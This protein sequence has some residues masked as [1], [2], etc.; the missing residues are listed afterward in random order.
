M[1]GLK[2]LEEIV[3]RLKALADPE[4]IELKARKFN[5]SAEGSLGIYQKDLK[6]LSNEIVKDNQLAV[7]LFD[8]GIYEA[9]LICSRIF[10][11]KD[12]TTDLM[13]KWVITFENWEIVDSFCMALF[14]H[15]S[16]AYPKAMEWSLREREFEKRSG[17][18]IM[19][20]YCMAN[21]QAE[22]EEY[23]D[24]LERIETESCDDRIYVKKA[25]NWALRNIG[26]RNPDLKKSAISSSRKI[27][28]KE[29]K[30][31]QWIANDALKEF[32]KEG[33][34]SSDYPRHLYRKK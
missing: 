34:R 16:L 21:K 26:K 27:L 7:D 23:L 13:E 33:L 32:E 12:L 5:I 18:A 31:A 8:T 28:Q 24:F 4:K 25:A 9:R 10:N 19:A 22:N 17:F 1:R 11:P 15:S 14:A 2:S 3:L 20:A 30:A 29:C 6:E